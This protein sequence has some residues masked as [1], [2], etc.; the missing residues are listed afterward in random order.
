MNEVKILF[1]DLF[2]LIG[3]IK[4]GTK[5]M[6]KLMNDLPNCIDWA[7]MGNLAETIM[8]QAVRVRSFSDTIVR[9]TIGFIQDGPYEG[10]QPGKTPMEALAEED[11][12]K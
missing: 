12:G 1:A 11:D 6:Q 5:E 8:N 3:Q 7:S 2:R 9:E 4:A 10:Q